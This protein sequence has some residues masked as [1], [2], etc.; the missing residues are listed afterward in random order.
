MILCAQCVYI[1]KIYCSW[2]Q[3]PPLDFFQWWLVRSMGGNH[4]Q[5]RHSFNLP[6]IILDIVCVHI[7]IHIC[8][9]I[10]MHIILKWIKSWTSKV[11]KW[12]CVPA[13]YLNLPGAGRKKKHWKPILT[14]SPDQIS[15][16]QGDILVDDKPKVSGGQPTLWTHVL[17][18][19][20]YNRASA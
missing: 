15:A 10:I 8:M 18:D 4:P 12:E 11:P 1:H 19:Q 6:Q 5:N 2:F 13:F 3:S 16:S 17:F 7:C 20:A 9:C 14:G